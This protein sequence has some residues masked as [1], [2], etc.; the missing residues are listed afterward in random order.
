MMSSE[1]EYGDLVKNST[2]DSPKDAQN[3]TIASLEDAPILTSLFMLRIFFVLFF[4]C[5]AI[6]LMNLMLGV[7]VSDLQEL[8]R[9]GKQR[10][11][12]KQVEC[13]SVLEKLFQKKP[14][15]TFKL[16][17]MKSMDV[18]SKVEL[19]PDSKIFG[20]D[21]KEMILNKAQSLIETEEKKADDIGMKAK[22]D[23]MYNLSKKQSDLEKELSEMKKSINTIFDAVSR[24]DVDSSEKTIDKAVGRILEV[25]ANDRKANRLSMGQQK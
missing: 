5:V 18:P 13:I 25:I 12:M 22:I 19:K 17:E 21:M 6:V 7:A 24:K 4:I 8:S 2:S 11:L 1:F 20:R 14:F 16:T 3:S 15:S 23:H 9:G 10:R